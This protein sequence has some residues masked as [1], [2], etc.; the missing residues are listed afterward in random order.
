MNL[1]VLCG[2]RFSLLLILAAYFVPAPGFARIRA[3]HAQSAPDADYVSAL[4]VANKFLYAWQNHDE[5]TGLLLLTDALKKSSTEDNIASFFSSAP[6]A[7]YEI[8]R[9]RKLKSGLYAFPLA[10]YN[11]RVGT[12]KVCPR[13]YSQLN[14]IKT[15]KEDWAIDKLP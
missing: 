8:G 5:E 6:V 3:H 7:T 10:L 14:V 1:R 13:R 4:A 12:E 11:S 9:G 2:A 15:G